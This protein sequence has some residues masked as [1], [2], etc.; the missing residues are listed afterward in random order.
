MKNSPDIVIDKLQIVM[1]GD[2][3]LE[4]KSRNISDLRDVTMGDNFNQGDNVSQTSIKQTPELREVLEQLKEEIKNIPSA[5]KQEVAE[6]HYDLL[7][8]YI[9]QN[10][11][12][13]IKKS[14]IA[15]NEILS[16]SGSIFTIADQF[17]I[18]IS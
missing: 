7:E 9:E 5:D 3:F 12:S 15:L 2:G 8:E 4:D 6:M 11:P 18:S 16:T 14:L 10:E 17:G 1:E 13:K